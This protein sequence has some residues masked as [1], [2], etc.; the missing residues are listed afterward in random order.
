[1]NILLCCA[2]GM[3]SSML[4]QKMREEVRSRGLEDIKIGACAKNQLYRYLDEAD[5]LLLAPQL[6]FL[7]NEINKMSE[8]GRAHV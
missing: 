8:I 5:V 7:S 6:S 1:M 3:S 4:V 2:A